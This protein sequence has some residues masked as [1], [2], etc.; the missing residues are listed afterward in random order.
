MTAEALSKVD[1]T[2]Y[3]I[4]LID[5]DQNRQTMQDL[6]VQVIPTVIVF[7]DGKEVARLPNMMSLDQLP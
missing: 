6:G 3:D 4:K 1:T 5:V 2:K 7:K